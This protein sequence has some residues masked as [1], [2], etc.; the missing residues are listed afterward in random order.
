MRSPISSTSRASRPLMVRT[1]P[2]IR[3]S[4]ARLPSRN[5]TASCTIVRNSTTRRSRRRSRSLVWAAAVYPATSVPSRSKNAPTSGPSGLAS[6]SAAGLGSRAGGGAPFWG[7][8]V[9]SSADRPGSFR[10]RPLV[11]HPQL[12]DARPVMAACGWGPPSFSGYTRPIARNFGHPP[13]TSAPAGRR[14]RFRTNRGACPAVGSLV[15]DERVADEPLDGAA[16]G[17]G[18]AEDVPRRQQVRMLL[19]ELVLEPGTTGGRADCDLPAAW[20]HLRLVFARSMGPPGLPVTGPP[21]GSAR[22]CG[23]SDPERSDRLSYREVSVVEVQEV[24]RAWLSGAG[25][26]PAAERAGV[27]VKTARRYIEAAVA[28]GLVRDG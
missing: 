18:I 20:D 16:L 6:T 7:V 4:N 26:R 22:L 12:Q 2:S 17:A 23:S 9:M 1:L 8:V 19:V 24:L 13:S 21:A 11:P 27:N 5:C 10:R 3:V 25:A 14:C 28:A 15:V